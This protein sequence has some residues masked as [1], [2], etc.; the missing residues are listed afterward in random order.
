MPKNK[1]YRKY[2][3]KYGKN[4]RRKFKSSKV[5]RNKSNNT[6]YRFTRLANYSNIDVDNTAD[7]ATAY[8]FKL[9]DLPNYTEF[10]ALYDQ[11]RIRYIKLM[12]FFQQDPFVNMT[13]GSFLGRMYTALDFDDATSPTE[14]DIQQMRYVKVKRPVGIVK[15]FLKPRCLNT[16][17]NDGITN[18][19]TLANKKTWIDCSNPNVTHYGVKLFINKPSGTNHVTC[20]VQAKFYIEFKNPR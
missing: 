13:T 5:Y 4:A 17:Y 10:T 1:T 8:T 15:R 7:F 18:A 9:S 12:F 16:I 6:V 14:A 2:S 19:Y 11:Y 20:T 3:K